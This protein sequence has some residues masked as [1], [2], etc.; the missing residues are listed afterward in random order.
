MNEFRFKNTDTITI[1]NEQGIAYDVFIKYP[2]IA[3]HDIPKKGYPVMYLLDGN[4]TF[5][6][7][8]TYASVSSGSPKKEIRAV[9]QIIVG[10][11]AHDSQPFSNQ[12]IYD[13]TTL[14]KPE[15]MNEKFQKMNLQAKETGGIEVF[16]DFLENQIKPLIE[17]RF[18]INK[19]N[20]TIVGHSLAGYFATYVFLK[21]RQLFQHYVIGSP[22]LWWNGGEIL[23]GSENIT[24]GKETIKLLVGDLEPS[25]MSER[26]ETFAQN[27]QSKVAQINFIKY[28]NKNHLDILFET[29][30]QSF[31]K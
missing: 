1:E 8:I 17:E 28:P 12:R 11:T 21:K 18:F 14:A 31:K 29:V 6:T 13:F 16:I 19:E 27:L 20:Q 24:S 4:A 3:Q 2:D 23:V 7:A 15:K 5:P 26:T 30:F 25:F 10:I 9:P 22:S